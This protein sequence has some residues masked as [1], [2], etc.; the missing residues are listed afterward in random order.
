M[1]RMAEMV[2]KIEDTVIACIEQLREDFPS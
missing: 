1:E 2:Q